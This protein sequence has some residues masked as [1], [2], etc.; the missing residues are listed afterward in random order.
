MQTYDPYFVDRAGLTGRDL[1]QMMVEYECLCSRYGSHWKEAPADNP[2]RLLRFRRIQALVRALGLPD[3]LL[4]VVNGDFLLT[5]N[6]ISYDVALTRALELFPGDVYISPFEA[7]A[8]SQ[9]NTHPNIT[10]ASLAMAFGLAFSQRRSISSAMTNPSLMGGMALVDVLQRPFNQTCQALAP[11]ADKLDD[12]LGFL[13]EPSGREVPFEELV[14][15]W[16]WPEDDLRE[17]DS[18]WW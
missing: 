10:H 5:S 2:P 11:I 14:V 12:F 1:A 15:E 8:S 18:D 7:E 6:H 17:V 16:G 3:D 9:D 4:A 13:L